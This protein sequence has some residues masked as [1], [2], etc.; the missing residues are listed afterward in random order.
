MFQCLFVEVSSTKKTWWDLKTTVPPDMFKTL[1]N[2]LNDGRFSI[3]TGDRRI[4]EPSTV[5]SDMLSNI[6]WL[7]T[8]KVKLL[9]LFTEVWVLLG[10]VS[11]PFDLCSY[12]CC[13]LVPGKNMYT[14]MYIYIYLPF[15]DVQY[16][17]LKNLVIFELVM[18][19]FPGWS[20]K[21]IQPTLKWS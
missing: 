3:S 20:R 21:I 16:I 17:L 7:Q 4:S 10:G 1:V 2:E 15:E 5:W 13:V 9:N 8:S 19:V 6:G 12:H 18:L 11:T 14:S